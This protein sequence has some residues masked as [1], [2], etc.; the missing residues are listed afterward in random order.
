MN[1]IR[2]RGYY[3]DKDTGLYYLQ[4]RYYDANIGRFINS[5]DSSMLM[6]EQDTIV[7]Y[8]LFD[9]CGNNHINNIDKSGKA[10]KIINKHRY[11]RKAVV[12]YINKWTKSYN[13]S[14]IKATYDCTNFV[15]QCLYAGG[16]CMNYSWKCVKNSKFISFFTRS[17]FYATTTWIYANSLFYYVESDMARYKMYRIKSVDDVK[18]YKKYMEA[19]DLIFFHTVN[20]DE[21]NHAAIIKSIEKNKVNYAQHQPGE[22]RELIQRIKEYKN[23]W[24]KGWYI[25]VVHIDTYADWR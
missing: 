5:D 8:N 21:Y 7:Q 1:P 20:K 23:K 15:S 22:Y 18:K 12:K 17:K 14:F 10:K 19:G 2:Y 4:S 24:A 13:N 9:Y 6:E 16:F 25:Y 3:Y 11:D